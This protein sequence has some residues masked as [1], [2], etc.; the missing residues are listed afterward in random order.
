MYDRLC[1]CIK[2][3][4]NGKLF[5][6]SPDFRF[7]TYVFTDTLQEIINLKRVQLPV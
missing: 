4:S 6:L 3:V 1:I 7:V 5:F 2:F